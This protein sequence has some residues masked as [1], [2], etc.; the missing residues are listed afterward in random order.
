MTHAA[1]L[2]SPALEM[3]HPEESGV[4]KPGFS[5]AAASLN[6]LLINSRSSR[7]L[8]DWHRSNFHCRT[9]AVRTSGCKSS[10][11]RSTTYTSY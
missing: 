4:P 11:L 9:V 8:P 5:A 7:H 6:T 10:Y 2:T 1:M 3:Q